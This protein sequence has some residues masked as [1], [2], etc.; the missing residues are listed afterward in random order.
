MKLN[1]AFPDT[2]AVLTFIG[3]LL[4]QALSA[5]NSDL[6]NYLWVATS[7]VPAGHLGHVQSQFPGTSKRR[8]IIDDECPLMRR[9]AYQSRHCCWKRETL[10]DLAH[11]S[12]EMAYILWVCFP[13]LLLYGPADKDQSRQGWGEKVALVT[14]LLE[15]NRG[16]VRSAS[17]LIQEKVR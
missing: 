16:A 13:F 3:I 12:S 11:S 15:H 4:L 5:V 7:Q 14:Q 1:F 17:C 2:P 9:K 6:G 10:S 8:H